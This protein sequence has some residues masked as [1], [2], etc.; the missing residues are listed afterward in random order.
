MVAKARCTTPSTRPS[1][2][3][4]RGYAGRKDIFFLVQ[5]DKDCG[6]RGETA[7]YLCPPWHHT[8]RRPAWMEVQAC[9]DKR[10]S[11]F[12]RGS[13]VQL[14]CRFSFDGAGDRTRTGDSLLGR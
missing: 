14:W 8:N 2:R 12:L 11:K 9:V 1:D 3:V 13:N 6:K 4:F 7:G 10:C 5:A